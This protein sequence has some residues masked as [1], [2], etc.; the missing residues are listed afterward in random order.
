MTSAPGRDRALAWAVRASW[1]LLGG[2]WGAATGFAGAH[3]LPPN[4]DSF[5]TL[6][7]QGFFTITALLG[8]LLGAVCGVAV[9][10]GTEKALRRV[11]VWGG[12]ALCVATVVNGL[13]I[14]SLV[15]AVQVYYPAFRSAAAT[16]PAQPEG[17]A[18]APREDPCAKPPP[19]PQ[20]RERILWDQECR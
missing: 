14:W 10:G 2:A 18:V 20:S 13:V 12:A 11:G 15:G 9:G 6:F 7:A 16:A 8:L 19:P 4:A 17:K 3:H 1:P 5:G